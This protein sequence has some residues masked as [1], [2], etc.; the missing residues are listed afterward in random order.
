MYQILDTI[1]NSWTVETLYLK[2]QNSLRLKCKKDI[3]TLTA[4]ALLLFRGLFYF[5]SC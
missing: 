4:L 5:M 2:P 1:E 3:L